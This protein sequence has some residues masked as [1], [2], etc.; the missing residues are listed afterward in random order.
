MRTVLFVDDETRI[1]HSIERLFCDRD[2]RCLFASDA[3]AAL[4]IVAREEVGVVVSD[5][6]M[7]GMRG[8]EMLSRVKQICPDTVR[9]LMTAYADLDTAIAAINQSEAFRFIVKPWENESLVEMVEESLD[10]YGLVVSLGKGDETIYR[11]VAQTVEM[12]DR[13]TKGHC[14]RVAEYAMRLAAALE[15]A[16]ARIVEIKHGSWLHDCGKIGV[17]EAILNNAGPLSGNDLQTVKK[18]PGWGAD[19]ARQ[20][21]MP[22]TVINIILYHHERFGGGGYP[23]GINGDKIP[24]EARIV[25]IADVFDALFSDRSYRKAYSLDETIEIMHGM[26]GSFFDPSL[27]KLFVLLARKDSL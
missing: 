2:M 14:D 1:L 10:R 11:T 4:E 20:A 17:P 24:L 16:P 8:V 9:I 23:M 6:M 15:L 7:P 19:L 12:K 3:G 25:C 21:R 18:H 5:N 26:T 13:Y 27:M 22:D